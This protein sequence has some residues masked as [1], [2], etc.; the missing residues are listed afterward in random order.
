[1]AAAQSNQGNWWMGYLGRMLENQGYRGMVRLMLAALFVFIGTA[2]WAA[3]RKPS[4]EEARAMAEQCR[5][6]SV[7]LEQ[8]WARFMIQRDGSDFFADNRA[9]AVDSR[10][11]S[12]VSDLRTIA[13]V[14]E[15]GDENLRFHLSN[16]RGSAVGKCAGASDGSKEC[17]ERDYWECS[18]QLIGKVLGVRIG[19]DG[20]IEA[21]IKQRA[22]NSRSQRDDSKTQSKSVAAPGG[23]KPESDKVATFSAADNAER[24]RENLALAR[25][26]MPARPELIANECVRLDVQNGL[27]VFKN[28]CREQIFVTFCYMEPKVGSWAAAYDCR[29][30]SGLKGVWP[31]GGGQE[32]AHGHSGDVHWFACRAP[33]LSANVR[34]NGKQLEGTCR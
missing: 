8:A 2:A 16:I 22:G 34:F 9:S 6:Q 21:A 18:A 11:K 30:P 14:A 29:K 10:L 31:K 24:E 5:P 7:A 1:M 23:A 26:A 13:E 28:I 4:I 27:V 20:S 33:G 25:R 19:L 3:A 32:A 15:T 12:L 17:A